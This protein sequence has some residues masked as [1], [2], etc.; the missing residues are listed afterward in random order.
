MEQNNL[1]VSINFFFKGEIEKEVQ[2][3]GVFFFLK[4]Y[5]LVNSKRVM[6]ETQETMELSPFHKGQ[7]QKTYS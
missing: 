3:K 2:G 5:W 7:L 6:F 1:Q 4:E